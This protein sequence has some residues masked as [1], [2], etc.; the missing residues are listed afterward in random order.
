M[1]DDTMGLDMGKIDVLIDRIT[2]QYQTRHPFQRCKKVNIN[3]VSL[4][5]PKTMNGFL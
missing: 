5:L 2:K 4:D 1:I 3:I